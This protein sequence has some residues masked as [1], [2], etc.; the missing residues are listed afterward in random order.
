MLESWLTQG[1]EKLKLFVSQFPEWRELPPDEYKLHGSCFIAGW[2]LP[3][4]CDDQTSNLRIL[5]SQDFPFKLPRIAVFP[6]APKLTW[7][8]LEDAGILCLRHEG[9]VCSIEQIED[10]LTF[11]LRDARDLVNEWHYGKGLERFEDEFQSYWDHWQQHGKNII[12]LCSPNG[13]SRWV[14]SFNEEKFTIVADDE[15]ALKSWVR[16]Y[17]TP[18]SEVTITSIPL[19][20]LQRPPHPKEY[21]DTPAKLLSLIAGDKV[22]RGMLEKHVRN[23]L[24]KSKKVMF[25]FPGRH[26]FGFA[27]LLLSSS[28][29]GAEKGFRKGKTPLHILVQRFTAK[30]V[31]IFVKRCDVSWVHGRDHNTDVKVLVGKTVL[32]LG[33]GSIGSG[34]AELLAKMGVGKIIL[35]DPETMTPENSSRH[36]LGIRSMKLDKAKEL[37]KNLS[38][39]FPH[40]NFV[41]Y[42]EKWEYCHREFPSM[43]TS[44]DLIV[45]TIGSWPAESRLN[46]LASST[47][48]FPPVLYGWLEEHAAAGHAAVFFKNKG[49]LRC[50]TDDRGQ[51]RLPITIWPENGTLKNVPLCGGLFQPYGAIEL[52][53]SQGLVADLAADVLLG[54]TVEST[55]HVWIGSE[56]LLTSGNGE[57]NPDWIALHGH[58]GSGGKIMCLDICADPQCLVCG[59]TT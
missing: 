42:P 17:F 37:A 14:P 39:R 22:A 13:D 6:F 45:S 20:K 5:I 41:S 47:A 3:R 11:L 38:K 24:K 40:L 54:R 32:L 10:E 46:I 25:A 4:L 2:E 35:V 51:A 16:N 43:F 8:N 58:P 33:V 52:S 9:S 31:G 28:G 21:P 57:W 34:V 26:G 50:L 27:G 1:V 23:S 29:K 30:P 53:F 19:I 49:C 7:P 55:H 12:S 48:D 36:T 59:V 15:E 18:D 44:V 56:K